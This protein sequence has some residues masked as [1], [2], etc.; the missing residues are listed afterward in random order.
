MKSR[1]GLYWTLL[2]A[3]V[4]LLLIGWFVLSFLAEPSAVG[5]MR[6][7]LVVIGVGSLAIGTIGA[8]AGATMLIV[9]RT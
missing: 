5:R 4:I 9:R 8:V 6:T 3:G 1:R 2:A 7:A